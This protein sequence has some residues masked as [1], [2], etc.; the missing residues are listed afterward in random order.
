MMGKSVD[1]DVVYAIA[2]YMTFS[3]VT[4]PTLNGFTN[5][6]T[7]IYLALATA[8]VIQSLPKACKA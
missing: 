1:R 3:L 8:I 2:G 7:I 4:L 6:A 5:R